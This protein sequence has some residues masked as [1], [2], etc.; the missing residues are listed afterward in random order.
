LKIGVFGARGFI[1]ENF[2]SYL[3]EIGVSFLDLGRFDHS[4]VPPDVLNTNFSDL[5]AIVWAAS[6]VNPKIANESPVLVEYELQLWENFI[7]CIKSLESISKTQ[8]HLI[9]LSSGGCVYDG[10][11]APFEVGDST[12]G[13][14]SYGKMK[15]KMEAIL[16]S[17]I[18][19]HTILRIANAYGPQQPSGR[20]QGVFAEWNRSLVK[21]EPLMIFGSTLQ[22]RDYIHVRDISEGIFL[23]VK[24]QIKGV[25]NLGYGTGISLEYAQSLYSRFWKHR[26]NFEFHPNREIDRASFWL[27][28][29]RTEK[30]FNWRPKINLENGVREMLK[31]L[32]SPIL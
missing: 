4:Q 23:A 17:S 13:T 32:E 28:M 22:V 27:N 5:D 18:Q 8:L 7:K 14:N 1:G 16:T 25:Y 3:R 29:R 26:L 11:S 15:L 20:G 31:K 24:L 9:F 2:C 6:N 10:D 12:T 30:V 21:K 19:N